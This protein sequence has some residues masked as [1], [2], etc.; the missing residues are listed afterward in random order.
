MN[1]NKKETKEVML[2]KN[3]TEEKNKNGTK[4]MIRLPYPQRVK[5]KDQ[6]KNFLKKFLEI[7]RKLEINIPFVEAL[8]K[9]TMY[10]QFMKDIITK[11]RTLRDESVI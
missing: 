2:P 3:T 8:E 9:M 6:N 1:E 4:P 5:K 7:F 10:R 11:K